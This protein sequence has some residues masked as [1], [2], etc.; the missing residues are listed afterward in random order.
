MLSILRHVLLRAGSRINT[1]HDIKYSI[2]LR[3]SYEYERIMLICGGRYFV[4]QRVA[5]RKKLTYWWSVVVTT[6]EYIPVLL[7]YY[8]LQGS[9]LAVV[10]VRVSTA[11][12]NLLWLQQYLM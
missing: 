4:L 11:V 10:V 1:L 3:Y 6:T 2:K 5:N 12:R 7:P 8:S 9:F